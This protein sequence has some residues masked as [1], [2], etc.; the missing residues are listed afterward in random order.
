MDDYVL[1]CDGPKVALTTR[2]RLHLD[3]LFWKQFVRERRS[4]FW[5]ADFM[6]NH[7]MAIL[8]WVDVT[9]VGREHRHGDLLIRRVADAFV[10]DVIQDRIASTIA[11]C[12]WKDGRLCPVPVYNSLKCDVILMDHLIDHWNDLYRKAVHDIYGLEADGWPYQLFLLVR[13]LFGAGKYDDAREALTSAI[14][15]ARMEGDDSLV[16][17]FEDLEQQLLAR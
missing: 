2:A 3:D 7:L 11:M 17:K 6:L 1:L 8:N 13:E 5:N 12:E 16:A 14:A 10:F 9:Q 15:R 4:F